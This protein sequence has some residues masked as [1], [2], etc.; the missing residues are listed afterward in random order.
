M[1]RVPLVAYYASNS[2]R[3]CEEPKE[4]NWTSVST[5]GGSSESGTKNDQQSGAHQGN[6]TAQPVTNQANK[7]LPDNSAYC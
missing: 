1:V 7:N 3:N 5:M 2:S 4:T 6:L